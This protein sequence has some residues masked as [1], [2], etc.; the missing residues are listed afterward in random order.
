LG[1]ELLAAPD[2]LRAA[3]VADPGLAT[4]RPD[5]ARTLLHML[6]DWPGHRAGAA[7]MAALLVQAGA[8]VNAAFGGPEHDE[9]PLHWAAS[10]DDVV[11]VDALLDAGADLEARGGTIAGGTALDDAVG[12]EQW[13]AAARLLERGA[14]P[15]SWIEERAAGFD[16]VAAWVRSLSA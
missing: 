1:A 11:M 3:L 12:Y 4:A 9:T 16:S 14:V 2:A 7:E 6:A 10:A 15:S 5:G 8:D 13:R